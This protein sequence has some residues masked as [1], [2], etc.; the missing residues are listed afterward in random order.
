MLRDLNKRRINHREKREVKLW[1]GPYTVK[2]TL[3]NTRSDE[4]KVIERSVDKRRPAI[5]GPNIFMKTFT[6]R[7]GT[8]IKES[9][10]ESIGILQ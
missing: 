10:I 5:L 2:L 7:V 9:K 8:V 4:F 3:S 6:P 1:R